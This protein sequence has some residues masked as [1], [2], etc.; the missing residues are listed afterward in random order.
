[1][2]IIASISNI[3]GRPLC[4]E[5][6][7]SMFTVGTFFCCIANNIT[8]MLVGRS[9]QGIGGGGIQVLSGVII[10]DIVPLRHRPKWYGMVL[11]AWALGT[12]AGP[13]IGGAIAQNTTWRWVFYLMYVPNCII[14]T[15]APE[16][17]YLGCF[18]VSN[19]HIWARCCPFTSKTEAEYGKFESKASASRLGRYAFVYELYHL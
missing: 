3:F 19:M 7:L 2:P 15:S 9:I 8:V 5:F 18:Q 16:L 11:A 13:I 4:L 12:C 14:K 10:T 6:A 17:I 1:M